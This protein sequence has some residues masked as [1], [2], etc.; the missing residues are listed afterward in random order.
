MR[1]ITVSPSEF[2]QFGTPA[3]EFFLITEEASAA[4]FRLRPEQDRKG[5]LLTLPAGA[6]LA[7][8]IDARVPDGADV[9]AVCPGRFLASPSSESLGRRKLLV[10][11][12][13]STPL[14]PAHVGYFVEAAAAG[15]AEAQGKVADEFFQALEEAERVTIVNAEHT[16]VATVDAGHESAVWNQQAGVLEPG[17]QQIVPAGELSMLP[18]DITDFDPTLRLPV[19]GRLI[20]LGWPIVHRSADAS[21]A[22]E[23][24]GL[25]TALS[26]LA[27]A[28]LGLDVV[29]GVIEAHHA[30]AP[31]AAAAAD[32]LD[33]LFSSDPR[34]RVLWELGFGINPDFEVLPANCGPNE[35]YG[36]RHGAVHLGVGL[37]PFTRFALTFACLNSAVVG[38]N[39]HTVLGRPSTAGRKLRRLR[40]SSC[41]CH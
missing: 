30:L 40:S 2:S 33:G 17:E 8:L 28:P 6:D 26:G 9:V 3:E 10:L 1:P 4:M 38:A 20:V 11:P 19:S 34:Y 24:A 35:V 12:A 14:E 21:T 39:G 41:G 7:G 5:T 32:A 36:G 27:L 23:Q 18:A 13:G 16:A 25:F 15:D 31:G 37:T 22:A 29:D